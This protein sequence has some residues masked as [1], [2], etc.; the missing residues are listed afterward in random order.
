[1][2]E[3]TLTLENIDNSTGNI[4]FVGDVVVRGE[5][6]AGFTVQSN[7]SITVYGAVTGAK[8][9]AGGMINI[10]SG[11]LNSKLRATG[12]II[13][14]FF[15]NCKIET[16]ANIEAGSFTFCTVKCGG[17]ITTRGAGAIIG[18]TITCL[19]NINCNVI[20]TKNFTKTEIVV[21]NTALFVKQR[22]ELME[23][24]ETIN[25]ELAQLTQDIKYLL[26]KKSSVGKLAPDKQSSLDYAM[27]QRMVKKYELSEKEKK[28]NEINELL[29]V[30]QHNEIV[31]KTAVYPNVS[32]RIGQAIQ[33]ITSKYSRAKFTLNE[34][35]HTISISQ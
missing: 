3:T 20:G 23:L 27:R 33:Q 14:N 5:V 11:C 31:V 15:E 17:S 12:N 34:R 7:K 29:E 24:V 19:G 35:D 18:G 16:D 9:I 32:I 2:V 6:L 22:D 4:N 13:V 1:M 8:L 26:E 10:K 21:G 30:K 25:G 28:I